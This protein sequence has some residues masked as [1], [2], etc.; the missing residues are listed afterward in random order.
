MVTIQKGI[1]L[2]IPEQARYMF[3]EMVPG[4]D[5]RVS[6]AALKRL[7]DGEKTVIG[8]GQSLVLAL[9][10][11]ISDLNVF[12]RYAGRGF[13]VPSTPAALWCW[14]RGDDRGDLIHRGR[15][16]VQATAG[17]FRLNNVVDAFKYG[18]GLD[19]TGF[20]DGTENP[21]D[22]AAMEAGFVSGR[23]SGLD[24]SSFVATQRWIHDL[25]RFESMKPKDQDNSI[26]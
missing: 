18:R 1:F 3:F 11:T 15:S 14:S 17:A 5:P 10:R 2:P 25:D 26:G 4:A 16:L 7:V 8:F 24:G 6:L 13:E 23:G 20:E 9:G 19:L 12:P 21:Q 22:D